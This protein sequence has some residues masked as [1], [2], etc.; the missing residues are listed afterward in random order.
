MP[1]KFDDFLKK[2]RPQTEISGS[3]DCQFCDEYVDLAKFDHESKNLIWV[4]RN[5]HASMLEE[6]NY[7]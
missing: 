5:G 4:C 7:G 3:F 1:N 6:F 2:A